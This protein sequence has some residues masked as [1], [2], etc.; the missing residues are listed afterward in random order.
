MSLG[1]AIAT[2][3]AYENTL[4][5]RVQFWKGDFIEPIPKWYGDR[6]VFGGG[7]DG[8]SFLNVIDYITIST[9][10][11]AQDFGDLV[12]ARSNATGVSDGSR[13]C[14]GGGYDYDASAVQNVIDYITI[15]T[16]GNAQDFGDL[17]VGRL[18]LAGASNGSRGCF[19]GGGTAWGGGSSF[20][21]IDYITISTLGNASDFGDLTVVRDVMGGCFGDSDRGVFGSGY[22]GSSFL[23]VID[24]ITISTL[25]N[26]SDFGDLTV[27][28]EYLGGVSNGTRGCFGGGKNSSGDTN[29][30]DYITI[31]TLG[32]AQDFGD[33]TTARRTLAGLSGD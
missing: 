3:S 15:S 4:K 6:G 20:N 24:Y 14:F 18:H 9:L 17:T 11:N 31:S 7:Y 13:G 21:V 1:I 5:R 19:G 28:R 12:I 25:G 23:N 22:D 29:I 30:I 32:N 10:G 16:L 2:L 26:A 33:L 8:S 27:V